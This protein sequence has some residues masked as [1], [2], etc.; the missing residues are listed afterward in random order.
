MTLPTTTYPRILRVACVAV[1]TLPF[2]VAACGGGE[3]AP[4]APV[5]AANA[6]ASMAV[7]A[8]TAIAANLPTSVPGPMASRL[9]GLT[10]EEEG[11]LDRSVSPCDN[12]FEFACGGWNKGT[13]IP[14]D[15]SSWMRS[16]SV[17][18]E[19]NES[20]LKAILEGYKAATKPLNA[21]EAKLR[22]FYAA[23]MDEAAIDKAGATPLAANFASIDAVKTK[24][25]L[26]KLL[27]KMHGAG[28]APLFGVGAQQDFNDST[29]MIGAF[30]QA[31]LGLPDRDY[32]LSTEG[33]FP[34]LRTK[35]VAYIESMLTLAGE[36]N[37]KLV[38]ASVMQLETALAGKQMTKEDRREPK[39][40]YHLTKAEDLAKL[41]P[42][43]SWTAYLNELPVRGVKEFNVAQPEYLSFL[44]RITTEFDQPKAVTSKPASDP[45]ASLD[46][47]KA[48][49]RWYVLRSA[50]PALSTAFVNESFKWQQTLKG[51]KSLPPRW[52]RCVRATDGALGEA[53]AKPF[54]M[55][56]LGD[57]GKKNVH[58]MIV[59]IE[60]TMSTN[61]DAI[62]WMDDTTKAA[63]KR[64][65]G[66]IANKIAF[67]DRWRNYDALTIRRTGYFA[68]LIS[69]DRFEQ[70][71]MLAKIGKPVDRNEWYMTPPSV[72]AYYDPSM[73]EMVFPAGILQPPFYAKSANI[74]TNFG[75]IGM[76]MGHELT[77]G[78]DDE[79][80]QFDADGNLKDWWSPTVNAEFE[81]RASC[82]EQQF[83]NYEVVGAKVNGK[84]TLGENIADL[85][86][87][88]LSYYALLG[89]IAK[90]PPA[91]AKEGEA[92]PQQ[93]YFLGFAQAWCGR[94]RD[95]AMRLLVATN[96][97]SPPQFR[98]NGPLS[99]LPEFAAA[100]SCKPGNKMVSKNACKVW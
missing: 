46:A 33:K 57:D 2:V 80:R 31:G 47:I 42:D 93:R 53:L 17:I 58:D 43:F 50:A 3:P 4:L 91:P 60:T 76:V 22:D 88:K 14:D 98:V 35:Y 20:K 84:L 69:A 29:K 96:P 78:F 99:N 21:E 68:N 32:Y 40:V 26:A 61:I 37:A 16:F 54:V 39:K 72:N 75:G 65:L 48:Y 56:T 9:A 44:N 10:E 71:R 100:F 63:A 64:K 74:G 23:C 30:D 97:H 77:H 28:W 52:K 24:L 92:T 15:E 13:Q 81:K 51:T 90:M 8:T 36:K 89:A 27:G 41:A 70:A 85:G 18:R 95:E 79:G 34:E 86:G 6:P 11:A 25:D 1:T 59:N 49:L 82:V 67:P 38:A 87:A 12:F 5:V 83:S 19:Q 66:K 94:Y 73:N 55:Q 62:T 7:P 45:A